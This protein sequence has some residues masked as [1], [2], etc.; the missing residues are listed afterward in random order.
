[1]VFLLKMAISAVAI[2]ITAG[3][4]PGVRVKGFVSAFVLALVLALLNALV[5]PLM[6]LLTIPITILTFGLFLLVLNALV[7]MLAAAM[8]GGVRVDGFWWALAFSFIM[9]AI[10]YVMELVLFPGNT[11]L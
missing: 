9:S 8:V 7:I 1:M 2:L 5:Y 6:V 3:L 4:L 10:M 11:Q